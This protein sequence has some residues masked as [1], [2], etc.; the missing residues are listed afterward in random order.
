M[1]SKQNN[2]KMVDNLIANK[3]LRIYGVQFFFSSVTGT[4]NNAK[5]KKTGKDKK[6]SSQ[7][8]TTEDKDDPKE[9]L[10]E[11][12]RNFYPCVAYFI[13][14]TRT[15][16]C[17]PDTIFALLHYLDND[18]KVETIDSRIKGGEEEDTATDKIT[19]ELFQ[20]VKDHDNNAV[21]SLVKDSNRF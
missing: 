21:K 8:K 17:N 4:K 18:V 2:R 19:R 11:F 5:E 20:V 13:A 16:E 3:R 15:R 12:F 1:G 7:E 9:D 14:Y 10:D 6:Q